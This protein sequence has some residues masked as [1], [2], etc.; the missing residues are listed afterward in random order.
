MREGKD[1]PMGC[2]RAPDG[3]CDMVCGMASCFCPSSGPPDSE[4][5]PLRP[6]CCVRVRMCSRGPGGAHGSVRKW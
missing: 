4:T 3:G 1:V 5:K 2:F 6:G